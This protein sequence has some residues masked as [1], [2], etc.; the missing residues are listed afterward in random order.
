MGLGGTWV[1]PYCPLATCTWAGLSPVAAGS[2]SWGRS[3]SW[4]AYLSLWE[5]SWFSRE[6]NPSLQPA[7]GGPSAP[8]WWEQGL[9]DPLETTLGCQNPDRRQAWEA[10]GA[11]AD[12]SEQNWRGCRGDATPLKKC[13][14]DWP[15]CLA[16]S[17]EAF[18]TACAAPGPPHSHV[19]PRCPHQAHH[20]PQCHSS[21]KS[22]WTAEVWC[23]CHCSAPRCIPCLPVTVV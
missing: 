14:E 18:P 20:F 16:M 13:L 10:A 11:E 1:S 12:S 15:D 3:E 21:R 6:Y 5:M 4:A 23:R 9:P 17:E 2:P 22:S 19:H 8:P 7:S